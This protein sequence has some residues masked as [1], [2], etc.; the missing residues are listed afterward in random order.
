M[1][2]INSSGPGV[3]AKAEVMPAIAMTDFA[4]VGHVVDQLRQINVPVPR[5][6]PNEVAIR[7]AASSI[8]IDEI[9]AAQGTA[10]GRFFGP[11][12]V[13]EDQPYIMGS[14]ASGTVV[15]LGENASKFALGDS[16]VVIP[17]EM[18]EIGSWATY[19]CVKDSYVLAKPASLSH[20][21]AAALTM[22]SCV[23]WGAL[24]KAGVQA[25]DRC[26]VVGA[27]GAVGIMMVQI[28]H[29]LGVNVTGV[30]SGKNAG[31]V[32][33]RGATS[34]ID[35][36]T[37]DFGNV[38]NNSFDIVFDALGGFE[39]EQCALRVLP[40]NG[41]FITV[42]GPQRYI[43]ETKLSWSAF[44]KVVG[45]VLWRMIASR[46]RGP[47]YV[48]GEALPRKVVRPALAHIEE[49]NIRIPV[50][51]KIPFQLD[52]IKGAVTLLTSHRSKGRIVINF[53]VPRT[54]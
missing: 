46:V 15:G 23:A 28:L 4:K 17:N 44:S 25:N 54:Q 27:S 29:S 16:V 51:A 26:L 52:A 11:K 47:R 18:G 31:M 40:R 35:Y 42:V 20:V 6:K 30:C 2:D 37:H 7:L 14:S 22:A 38:G 21:Q 9:Y 49:N 1:H 50:Q 5:P 3:Y 33:A 36:T 10:L 24:I 12:K 8:H 13:S 41:R 43:G 39:T 19:R 48:F 34:V 32:R 45:H 53:D